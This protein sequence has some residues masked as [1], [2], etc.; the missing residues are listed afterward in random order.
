MLRMPDTAQDLMARVHERIGG[1]VERAKDVHPLA[2]NGGVGAMRDTQRRPCALH[3]GH[4]RHPR[5]WNKNQ[6]NTMYY[7]QRSNLQSARD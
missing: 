4:A 7:L 6:M 2:R 3:V 1:I 5:L